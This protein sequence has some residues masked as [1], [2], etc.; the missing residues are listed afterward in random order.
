MVSSKTTNPTFGVK[1]RW[2]V[3]VAGVMV[4]STVGMGALT[5]LDRTQRANTPETDKMFTP[6][7]TGQA[8]KVPVDPGLAAEQIRE[9]AV[10]EHVK[11]D[12]TRHAWGPDDA[13]DPAIVDQVSGALHSHS[14][15]AQLSVLGEG[16]YAGG[17]Y[18]DVM[19]DMIAR[20]LDRSVRAD[21]GDWLGLERGDTS[22]AFEAWLP[23]MTP[24]LTARCQSWSRS[25]MPLLWDEHGDQFGGAPW[26]E[27][28][29]VL[30]GSVESVTVTPDAA[31]DGGVRIKVVAPVVYTSTVSGDKV[32][33]GTITLVLVP[34]TDEPN[35]WL[36]LIDEASLVIAT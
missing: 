28:G 27:Q 13:P 10:R 35:D 31:E 5:Y 30:R 23:F 18:R 36:M 7:H 9:Q 34:R 29:A 19:I 11:Q 25:C 33:T 14:M 26:P 1:T 21:V 6:S 3:V 22:R 2:P 16:E 24:D 20:I 17:L 4:L 32:H 8:A 12:D 15:F